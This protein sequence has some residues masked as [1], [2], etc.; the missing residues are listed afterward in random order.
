MHVLHIDGIAVPAN[1]RAI[2]RVFLNLP[3]ANA[4]TSAKVKNFVGTFVVLPKGVGTATHDHRKMNVAFNVTNK[5]ADLVKPDG[6]L[7]VT[8]VP[9]TGP[10]KKPDVIHMTYDKV[11]IST[12]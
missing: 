7:T 6:K 1:E 4:Q 2:V 5:L 10:H 8:L 9:V 3:A 11:Y 12:K